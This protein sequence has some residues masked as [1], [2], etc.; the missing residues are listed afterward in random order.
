M[1]L[2]RMMRGRGDTQ[3]E[4]GD[5]VSTWAA[6]IEFSPA[7]HSV[8]SSFCHYLR[9]Y[10]PHQGLRCAQHIRRARGSSGRFALPTGK[11]LAVEN[12]FVDCLSCHR[13]SARAWSSIES[14]RGAWKF[15]SRI[16]EGPTL[17]TK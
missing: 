8:T 14:R 3:S 7:H 6:P 9:R 11:R 17:P 5:S 16:R 13:E 12:A 2:D 4:I 15:F 10:G 1:M